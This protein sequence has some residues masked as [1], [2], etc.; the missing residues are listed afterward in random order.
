MEKWSLMTITVLLALTVRWTV[1]LG[2]YSGAGKPPMYGDYEAQRH[3]QEITYNLPIRQWYFNTSDNDLLYWGLDYP[4][5]TAYHSFVCAY[6]AKLINPDW[7]AL[8]TSRGYESQPHKLFMRTTVFVADLLVYIPAV[9]LY[10]FSLKETSTKKKDKVANLWCSLSVL[11]KI[12]N[13]VSPQTQLK[14]SFAVT[15]LSL[16]PTCIKLTV[17]PS[18][19]GFKFALVS[20]ALSFF[21]FSFQVHEKSILLVSVPVC[22]IIN[23]I[24]FMATW[25]LLV[26][27]FSMLPLLL[28]DGLLL[29][30]AVT[31]LA[32]LAA[33]L[34]SFSIL[35]K[36]SAEDLQLKPFSLSL[37]GYVSWFKSFPK[38]VR[39]LF[40]LSVTLMGV[41]SAMSAAVPPP[42]RLPDLFPVSVS[43]ISCLHFLLFLVYFNI[44]ILWDSKN[45][46]SQKK[47]S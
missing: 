28:K 35:E 1:S 20:C 34:T 8:H 32:F 6:V 19:R 9:I 42:H 43:V 39:S 17:Q 12:K 29:A 22:L 13:I 37:K 38:M 23:E 26:S 27:T 15:F 7:I 24:P 10:C 16:L 14:L 40:L 41:L 25:F 33:C 5:L 21:L 4:P 18:L 36:T 31:T 3:W 44:V 11:I 45:S 2:S 30:Y 46:R 47:I